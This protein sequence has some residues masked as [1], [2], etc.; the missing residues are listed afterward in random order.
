MPTY[1]QKIKW[2]FSANFAHFFAILILSFYPITFFLGTGI[3]N[4]SIIILDLILIFEI[5]RKKKFFFL[6]NPTFFFLIG[7]WF[8][9]LLSLFLSINIENSIGRSIG[10]LRYILFVMSIIYFLNFNHGIYRT[11]IFNTWLIIFSV[12]SFDLVY[13]FFVGKNILGFSSYM[14]GRLASFFNDELMIGHFYYGFSLLMVS[15][16]IKSKFLEKYL[17]ISD[18]SNNKDYIFILGLL[19]ILI[20]FI[21]GERSN[22]IKTLTMFILFFI[23]IKLNINRNK[24]IIIIG[25]IFF[26]LLTINLNQGYKSRFVNQLLKPLSNN[27][28]NFILSNNYGDHYKIGVKIFSENKI[29]GVGLKNY[30]I[31]VGNKNYV[32]SSIHPHQIHIEILSELGL[33][34]YFSF[35]IFFIFSYLNYRKNLYESESDKYFKMA[36]WLFVITSFMPLLPSGSFFTSHAATI[37]WMN[38]AFMNLSQKNLRL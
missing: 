33:I 16:I 27:P 26:F 23:F 6:K 35:I 36:G 21:I 2:Q 32:N 4:L 8:I 9:L 7:L 37:F 14:P 11:I 38:Y 19:I 31:E 28:I 34:G 1:T 30:R 17:P 25:L 18:Q 22:F 5:I 13:E 12:I 29:F 15:Y 20:S 10:F 24:I 3:L